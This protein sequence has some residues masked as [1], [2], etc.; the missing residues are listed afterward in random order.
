MSSFVLGIYVCVLSFSFIF[1]ISTDVEDEDNMPFCYIN[2]KKW[3]FL[4]YKVGHFSI[5]GEPYNIVNSIL[6]TNSMPFLGTFE[7]K[8]L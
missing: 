7:K 3:S 6:G 8:E 2:Y 4:L 5:H 1:V